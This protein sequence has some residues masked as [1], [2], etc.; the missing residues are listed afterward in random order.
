MDPTRDLGRKWMIVGRADNQNVMFEPG[1]QL[2]VLAGGLVTTEGDMGGI[3]AVTN[4]TGIHIDH[5]YVDLNGPNNLINTACAPGNGNSCTITG[6]DISGGSDGSVENSTFINSPGR[7]AIIVGGIASGFTPERY[8]VRNNFVH[9]G[10]TSIP[11]NVNQN[12]WSAIYIEANHSSVLD[13]RIIN[14]VFPQTAIASGGIEVHGN[15]L[16]VRGNIIDHSV[17]GM[18]IGSDTGANLT[19][20]TVAHNHLTNVTECFSIAP[21]SFTDDL[22]R[23]K[24]I[25]NTCTVL[26]SPNSSSPWGI[27]SNVPSNAVYGVHGV[28]IDSDISGNTIVG[29]NANES[30]KCMVLAGV[31]DVRI[32][33]NT[34]ANMGSTGMQLFPNPFSSNL[35]DIKNNVFRDW[36]LNNVGGVDAIS[37]DLSNFPP[38][39]GAFGTTYGLHQYAKPT[40]PAGLTFEATTAGI[41]SGIEPT[42]PVVLGGTVTDG[43]VV[44][45]ARPV[46]LMSNINVQSNVF[47]MTANT[48]ANDAVR[49]SQLDN[50]NLFTN[51]QFI[52]NVTTNINATPIQGN[53]V[54]QV[55][56]D[57]G[58]G[59]FVRQIA[60][61]ILNSQLTNNPFDTQLNVDFQ[62]GLTANQ[63]IFWRFRD[64]SGASTLAN[65]VFQ[66]ATLG[67]SYQI[68]GSNLISIGLPIST[69]DDT[70]TVT[71]FG[72]HVG[73]SG[74]LEGFSGLAS[75][76]RIW[77]FNQ[78]GSLDIGINGT[79]LGRLTGAFTGART[80][81]YPDGDG[82]IPMKI[83]LVTTAAASDAVT[84]QGV[85]TSSHCTLTSRNALAATNIAT[86]Y[87]SAVA[88]NLV[89]VTHSVNAAMNYD[90]F[91]TSN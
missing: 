87:I 63:N 57:T 47:Q 31:N 64:K 20:V 51:V 22:V 42:W 17:P 1:A 19:D 7:N 66:P 59:G 65:W 69:F 11:G 43:T 15:Q 60:P 30:T 78:T 81:T 25:D 24:I 52:G 49:I 50:A 5:F 91:C 71:R 23:L 18:Y 33:D 29:V 45:T 37:L 6:I 80:F 35:V 82:A 27:I 10:G 86:T 56:Q 8:M 36:N 89:T 41:S 44:W 90:I 9:N 4:H 83:A 77:R 21:I 85:T 61:T 55:L 72:S 34:C 40:V 54:S 74:I 28:L 12:D 13:N 53:H 16:Q 67:M 32:H 48:P 26:K 39:W 62:A 46:F 68:S 79:N 14:D 3:Y 84:L 38:T 88:A 2:F 58:T 76:A 70:G 75:P 73:G